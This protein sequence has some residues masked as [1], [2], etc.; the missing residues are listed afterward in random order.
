MW[1]RGA[2]AM[3]LAPIASACG[4]WVVIAYGILAPVENPRRGHR[5]LAVAIRRIVP[6]AEKS[7]HFFNEVDEGL[8]FYLD[9][10]DL[11][12]VPETHPRYSAAYDLAAAYQGRGDASL[13]LEE[14]D[15]RRERME[16]QALLR[17]LDGRGASTHYLLIRSRLLDRYVREL[18]GRATPV[19]RESGLGRNELVLLRADGLAPL[20]NG[21]AAVRR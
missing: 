21:D 11:V 3:S 13:T 10:L 5:E 4:L 12:P 14:L 20:A 8:W 19:L 17:W 15:D 6:D 7:V 16:K 2:D 9:G 18:A 1:R